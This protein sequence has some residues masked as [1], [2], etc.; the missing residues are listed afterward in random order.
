MVSCLGELLDFFGEEVLEG[1]LV[2]EV[3]LV[4]GDEEVFVHAAE[5]VLGEGFLM[6]GAE[7]DADGWVIACLHLVG[8]IPV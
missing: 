6:V 1:G 2:W 4:L 8:A 3:E 5:G 7:E